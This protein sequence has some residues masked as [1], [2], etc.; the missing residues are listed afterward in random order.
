MSISRAVLIAQCVAFLRWR[1]RY[2]SVFKLVVLARAPNSWLLLNKRGP[3][4]DD[5]RIC[6]RVVGAWG[7]LM[8]VKSEGKRVPM[9]T[10]DYH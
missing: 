3:R 1:T 6:D 5:W 9:L 2:D 7:S 10:S 4:K 8:N